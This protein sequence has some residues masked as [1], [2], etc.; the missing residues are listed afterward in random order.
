MVRFWIY[1]KVDLIW[2]D[3]RYD[4]YEG[5]EVAKD[6]AKVLSGWS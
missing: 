6:D 4:E 5:K 1:L 2:S 3:N